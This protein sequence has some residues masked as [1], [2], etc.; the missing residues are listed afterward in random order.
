VGGPLSADGQFV[1][2][3]SDATN[4]VPGDTNNASDSFVH[5]RTS[6]KTRR[7]SIAMDGA[8]GNDHSWGGCLSGDGRL[9]TFDSN[10]DNLVPGDINGH[11]EDV[12][13]HDMD[14]GETRLV[15]LGL[16]G[17]QPS[18]WSFS[19]GISKNGQFVSWGIQF[20]LVFVQELATQH[21]TLVSLSSDGEY[22]NHL[23]L[24]AGI[25]GDGLVCAFAS[26]ADNL[27]P[28]DTNRNSDVF[29]NERA[30]VQLVGVP[31]NPNP[32]HFTISRAEPGNLALVMLSASGTDGFLIG[33]RRIPLT[34]DGTTVAGFELWPLLSSL[35]DATGRANTPTL[36]FPPAS[37]GQ[38]FHVSALSLEPA[39]GKIESITSPISL[40]TQ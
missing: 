23:C 9:V 24:P 16:N 31:K 5:D 26:S 12:F 10:A 27:V 28:G 18:V 14:T 4:L 1:V 19:T 39:T 37:S 20:S 22:P 36:I 7:V 21:P 3:Q 35:V 40:V 8:Q 11:T 6:G 29:V 32:F 2:F 33:G 38:T 30:D 15:S 34:L 25:S 17:K 13:L